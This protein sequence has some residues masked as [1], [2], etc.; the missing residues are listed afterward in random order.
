LAEQIGGVRV[1]T[2]VVIE[3]ESASLQFERCRVPYLEFMWREVG[4]TYLTDFDPYRRHP[5]LRGKIKPTAQSFFRDMDLGVIDARAA[6]SGFPAD[7]RTPCSEREAGRRDWLKGRWDQDLWIF[8]YGSLMWDPAVEFA[9]ARHGRCSGYQRSF[10]LWD[11]GGR[12]SAE[13]PGLMLALDE[14]GKCE[15]LA[16]RVE[17][18]KLD[19]ETFILFRREMIATAYRPI[20]LTVD[21]SA[22]PV[23]ALSFIANHAHEN[24]RPGIPLHDQAGMIARAEGIFGTNFDYLRNTHERL[25]LL[26]IEDTYVSDLYATAG[27]L[28]NT[29]S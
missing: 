16:F 25:E 18:G 22:G 10:C 9:E 19:H 20:W 15:G 13:A 11:E 4:G 14:G 1:E 5:E 12:G 26:G 7:W 21:T 6:E 29:A 8:G 28:R 2:T 17:A 24:I 23:E 27:A 3:V